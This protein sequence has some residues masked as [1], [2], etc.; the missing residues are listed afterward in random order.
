[1][2]V[3]DGDFVAHLFDSGSFSFAVLWSCNLMEKV[4][5]S[6]V[7]AILSQNPEKTKLFRKDNGERRGYPQQLENLG[8]KL[9]ERSVNDS[10]TTERLWH[11]LRN[12]IAHHNHRASFQETYDTLAIVVSFTKELPKTL[13]AWK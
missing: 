11:E 2:V 10:L 9:Q 1:V 5:D 6:T 4:I 3:D 13:Q 8:L 12:S 7:E